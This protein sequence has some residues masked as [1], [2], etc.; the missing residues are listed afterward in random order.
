MKKRG[1]QSVID[2]LKRELGQEKL[3][4]MVAEGKHRI[5]SAE[6]EAYK[7]LVEPI[8]NKPVVNNN[9][10]TEALDPTHPRKTIAPPKK[11]SLSVN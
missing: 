9:P 4:A 10:T 2:Q 11:V 3:R 6:F 7:S 1:Y 8:A 5:V